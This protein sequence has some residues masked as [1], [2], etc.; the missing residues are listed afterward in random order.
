MGL[1]YYNV[2]SDKIENLMNKFDRNEDWDSMKNI[3]FTSSEQW[4]ENTTVYRYN[5]GSIQIVTI[6]TPPLEGQ[7]GVITPYG[8]SGGRWVTG[9]GYR[10]CYGAKVSTNLLQY[11]MSFKADFSV[12]PSPG[13]SKIMNVYESTFSGGT[14]KKD[15]LGITRPSETNYHPATAEYSVIVNRNG[16]DRKH[17]LFLRVQKGS[18]RS[19][20]Q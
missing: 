16:N 3:E 12:V 19:E 18:Y 20:Y 2:P 14:K 4:D 17:S 7:E 10:N 6:E 9:S 11:S 15:W 1:I 5:D 13:K 8:V